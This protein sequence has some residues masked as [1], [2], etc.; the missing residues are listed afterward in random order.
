MNVSWMKISE[1]FRKSVVKVLLSIPQTDMK[2]KK[3]KSNYRSV[4]INS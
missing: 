2:L 1:S 3:I 4:N